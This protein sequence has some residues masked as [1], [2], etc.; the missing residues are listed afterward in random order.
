MTKSAS[1][2]K[3]LTNLESIDELK[4]VFNIDQGKARLMLLFSPT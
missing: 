4:E 1:F 3:K 2:S